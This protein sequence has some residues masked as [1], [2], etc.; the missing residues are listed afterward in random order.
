MQSS[1]CLISSSSHSP[2]SSALKEEGEARPGWWRRWGVFSPITPSGTITPVTF[3]N[4]TFSP[5]GVKRRGATW[6]SLVGP[7]E[8]QLFLPAVLVTAAAPAATNNSTNSFLSSQ[9]PDK[10]C[11]GLIPSFQI[12]CVVNL[13]IYS[14]CCENAVT[15]FY[16]LCFP[17][18]GCSYSFDLF[19]ERSTKH[20]LL[21]S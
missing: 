17:L 10:E 4:L 14:G 8:Q 3:R 21:F 11:V 5:G 1:I 9:T 2:P 6:S 20:V 13:F 19:L 16:Y 18:D 7:A 12:S 15:V